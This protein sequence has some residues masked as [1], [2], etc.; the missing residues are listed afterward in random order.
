VLGNEGKTFHPRNVRVVE[1]LSMFENVPRGGKSIS[2]TLHSYSANVHHGGIL[3]RIFTR[4]H[5]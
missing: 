3:V 4:K 1:F 5:S 2:L